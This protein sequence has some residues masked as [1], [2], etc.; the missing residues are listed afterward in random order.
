LT[1]DEVSYNEETGTLELAGYQA[2]V[3][4]QD[5]LTTDGAKALLDYAKQGLKVV[6][7]DGAAVETPYNDHGEEELAATIS[8]MKELSNVATAATANDVMEALQSL[9]VEPYTAFEEANQQL[10]TQTRQ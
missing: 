8:E 3:L 7:V 4:W 10:L 5:K 2:I 1:A 9:G 6:I